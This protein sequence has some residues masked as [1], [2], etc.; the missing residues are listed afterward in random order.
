L[1]FLDELT[2]LYNRRGFLTLA[3]QQLKT[4]DRAKR[5]MLLLFADF[6]DLKH[7]NDT[8][9]HTQGDLALIEV[10]DVLRDKFRESDIIARIGGDEFVVLA[11][12]TGGSSAD[13]ITARLQENLK[14]INAREG[15]SYKLSLS[16][17][18]AHYDFEQPCSI[19]ALLAR[20]DRAMYERKQSD[21]SG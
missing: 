13:A 19:D 17:G 5:E 6:D 18:I 8:L 11:T 20:A 12:E 16:M 7:I 1:A 21:T 10:A 3:E 2:G 15:R 14:A 9:G 4:A